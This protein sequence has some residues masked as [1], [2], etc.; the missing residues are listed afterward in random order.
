MNLGENKKIMLGLIEEYAPT[1]TMLTEDE[2]IYNRL[3]LVY[4]TN[5]QLLSQ[6]KKIL[7]TKKIEVTTNSDVNL[8]AS[9]PS[10]LYQLKR[11]VGLD[12]Y[13]NRKDIKFDVIGKKIYL[14]QEIGKYIIEYYAYPTTILT[15]TEDDFELEIDSDAQAVLPY[16]VADDILKVD[17]SSDY[18]AF[19]IRYEQ[20]LQLLDDTRTLVNIVV[21]D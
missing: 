15:D 10:D 13:N 19:K 7:K 2:D 16:M 1:N 11:V 21:E 5:Y 18:T 8:E 12:E 4:S 14:K 9:L 3:N 20:M 17:P 6:K